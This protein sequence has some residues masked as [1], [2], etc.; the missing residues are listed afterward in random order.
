[1]A[2]IGDTTLNSNKNI[3]RTSRRCLRSPESCELPK[4]RGQEC[5]PPGRIL[6]HVTIYK[7]NGRIEIN[8]IENDKYKRHI[9]PVVLNHLHEH[10]KRGEYPEETYYNE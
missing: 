10:H 2:S 8:S 4:P 1:M 5:N 3:L 6:G 7:L 9:L